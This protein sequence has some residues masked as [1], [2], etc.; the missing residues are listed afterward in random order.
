MKIIKIVI[1]LLIL[2]TIWFPISY[3]SWYVSRNDFL[4]ITNN[5]FLCICLAINLISTTIFLLF[6]W[7]KFDKWFD[8]KLK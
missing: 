3:I 1:E 4:I 8:S 6:I 5:I 7:G 2:T